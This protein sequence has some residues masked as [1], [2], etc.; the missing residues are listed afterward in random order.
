MLQRTDRGGRIRCCCAGGTTYS[1]DPVQPGSSKAPPEPYI[2]LF[3]SALPKAEKRHTLDTLLRP[4]LLAIHRLWPASCRQ[5]DSLRCGE[6]TAVATVHWTVAKSRLSNP[7]SSPTKPK[8]PVLTDW[9]FWF[10]GG[11]RIRTIEAIR[12]RFTV[13][14]L[15]PLGNSPIFNWLGLEPVDGL[16]KQ[17]CGSQDA[18]QQRSPAL[19]FII[20]VC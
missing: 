14:P 3:E 6:A 18:R 20:R 5:L 10:G 16:A 19:H 1:V 8:K 2:L 4:R 7:V 15:W 13:C 11:G 12:S 17:R 9:F